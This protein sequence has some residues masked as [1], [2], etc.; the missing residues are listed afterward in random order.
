[1]GRETERMLS[2]TNATLLL[3]SDK[4]QTTFLVVMTM[5]NIRFITPQSHFPQ[6]LLSVARI[7]IPIILFSKSK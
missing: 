6:P 4:H 3:R 2:R 5:T 7:V 1:M